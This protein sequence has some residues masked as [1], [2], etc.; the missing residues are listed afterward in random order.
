M[1]DSCYLV[2]ISCFLAK[3]MGATLSELNLEDLASSF[4]KD[5]LE[6]ILWVAE[7]D[8]EEV[9]KEDHLETPPKSPTKTSSIPS[10]SVAPVN[11]NL[12]IED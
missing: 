7:S 12:F 5:L 6:D 8:G 11:M 4:D 3:L 1:L 10:T 2:I 9:E